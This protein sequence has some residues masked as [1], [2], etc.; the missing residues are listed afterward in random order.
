MT[1]AMACVVTM[2]TQALGRLSI[3]WR[4]RR[5][6]RVELPVDILIATS[7]ATSWMIKGL[8]RMNWRIPIHS[9][10]QWSVN[11][12]RFPNVA[13]VATC[14]SIFG[15]INGKWTYFLQMWL[16]CV[17]HTVKN[18]SATI[19]SKLFSFLRTLNCCYKTA[20]ILLS[21]NRIWSIENYLVVIILLI[22]LVFQCK[23]S[24]RYRFHW[25]LVGLRIFAY[26]LSI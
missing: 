13:T 8:N 7:C 19:R 10:D 5:P 6:T 12:A 18:K 23:F 9:T 15:H 26:W 3:G 14:Q 20:M 24:H 17:R 11:E 1:L 21:Y 2:I 4:P 16:S 25:L 22:S